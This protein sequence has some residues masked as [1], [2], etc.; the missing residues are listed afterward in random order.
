MEDKNILTAF[1]GC[2]QLS[3]FRIDL[4][5]DREN[6]GLGCPKAYNPSDDDWLQLSKGCP[7]LN[8]IHYTVRDPWYAQG[9]S[10]DEAFQPR[11]QA[12]LLSLFHI[13]TYCPLL[14]TL[15]IPFIASGVI[16]ELQR[17]PPH[18]LKVLNVE[19]AWEGLY[20]RKL[21][22]MLVELTEAADLRY[23]VARLDRF[24]EEEDTHLSEFSRTE[25]W[26]FVAGLIQSMR[27]A[28]QESEKKG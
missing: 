18:K 15:R 9:L 6:D 7:A 23:T 17:G 25:Y 19:Q 28:R 12:T 27:E 1:H 10:G 22:A 11:P 16:P 4:Q 21:A 14:A 24:E 26:G 3:F 8:F 2:S 5:T 20:A 13:L